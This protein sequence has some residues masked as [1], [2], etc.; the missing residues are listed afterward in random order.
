MI[1]V[2]VLPTYCA[3]CLTHLDGPTR[4]ERPDLAESHGICGPCANSLRRDAGL[5]LK[6]N[7]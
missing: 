6:E 3:W 5:P 4:D 1:P 2:V 7:P